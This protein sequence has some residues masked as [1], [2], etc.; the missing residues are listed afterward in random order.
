MNPWPALIDTVRAHAGR[1]LQFG[2]IGAANAVL[3][4]GLFL[5]FVQYLGWHPVPANV[6]SYMI[7]VANS[8][9]LNRAI[10]FRAHSKTRGFFDGFLRF[11]A[12]GLIG[13]AISTATLFLFLYI[14]PPAVAKLASILVTMLWNYAASWLLVFKQRQSG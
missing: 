14:L 6:T 7:A 5:G 3:D 13:L 2:S 9:V 1:F 12:V 8:Y 11:L 4:F 10:T